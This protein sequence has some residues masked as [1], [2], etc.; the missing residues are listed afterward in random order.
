[1]SDQYNVSD[2]IA[3]FL[4]R[5]GV[6]TAFGIVSVHN[7]P[8]LDAISMRNRIRFVMA[9][10]EL[11][12]SHMAD[13]YARA[14]GQVGVLFSSTGPGAANSVAGLVEAR[15][16]SSPLL[17]FTG[18]T[19]TKYI[20][21]GMGGV[22]DV[23]DQLGMLAA[24]GKSAYRIRNATE[25]FAILQ[26]AAADALTFPRGPVSIE[27]PTDIQRAAVQR[28]AD[29]DRY[30][31][32]VQPVLAPL[33]EDIDALAEQLIKSK[34]PMLWLGRGAI[35]AREPAL[36]LLELGVGMVTSWAGRGVVPEEHPMNLG[37][38][39]GAG[40]VPVEEFY[41]TVDLMIV[42]GS[43]LRG[44]ETADFT[45]PLPKNLIQIDLDPSANGRTYPNTSFVVGD[46]ALVL[47]ELLKRVEGQRRPSPQYVAEFR[48]LKERTRKAFKN[49]LGPYAS[50]ADQ[51]AA[52]MPEDAIW[53]RDITINNSTWGNKLLPLRDSRQNIYP[54][55]AGIGQG[56]SLGIGAALAADGRKTFVMTGDGG[57]FLNLGE[58]YTATQER[59]DM[60]ILI[61]ND[62]G[63]GVIRHIQDKNAGG[64]RRF[65]VLDGPNLEDLARISDIPYWRVEKVDD[66]GR[67]VAEAAAV[68]GVTMIEVDMTKIGDHPPYYPY[69]PKV[70]SIDV[71]T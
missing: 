10:G 23:P 49:S 54:I 24:S 19:S 67:A 61:M 50:F 7:I 30:R 17:H 60:V 41:Q 48:E 4:E 5:L 11:G 36:K 34:R 45:V 9:R 52:V 37:S 63:Y 8:M 29:L 33:S 59:L 58:L 21:R 43:R 44:H 18:Q 3:E 71:A 32:P 28:P 26:R 62:R 20:D 25:A 70:E 66:F 15:F 40:L 12:A 68:K 56:L 55:G 22:H 57:F 27:V 51:L 65:D 53:A 38:L 6:D 14:S 64:R 47:S 69:G 13:G 42:A 16:A 39:N 35:G 31:G 2:L 46:A 1:M